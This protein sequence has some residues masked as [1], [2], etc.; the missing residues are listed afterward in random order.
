MMP[1][2]SDGIPVT[3]PNLFLPDIIA[4]NIRRVSKGLIQKND[5]LGFTDTQSQRNV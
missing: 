4:G 3:S 1:M 5:D 2:V